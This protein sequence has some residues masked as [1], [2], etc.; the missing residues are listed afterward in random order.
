[1]SFG[2]GGKEGA[3]V[4]IGVGRDGSFVGSAIGKVSDS[5]FEFR[6]AVESDRVDRAPN[7]GAG[8]HKTL[9]SSIDMGGGGIDSGAGAGVLEAWRVWPERS[10]EWMTRCLGSSMLS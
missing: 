6:D 2:V 10:L 7:D 5:L 8:D 3:V 9:P 4:V 1:M